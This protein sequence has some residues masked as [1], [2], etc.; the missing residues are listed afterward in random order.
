MS[1]TKS[2]EPLDF[3]RAA[4]DQP[5]QP[6]LTCQ[7]CKQPLRGSYYSVNGHG[8]CAGCLQQLRDQQRG[9]F[10]KAL[11]LGSVAG[12]I[13]A[14][15]YYG[16]REASG[17][18]LGLVT[19]VVGIAVGL[20]V[21]RGAG[22]SQSRLY[23]VLA[24]A[25]TYVAM[26]STHIPSILE[27]FEA[28]ANLVSV[29][30]AGVFSLAIPFFMVAQAEVLSLLIF[31]FGLWEAFRLSA[32]RPFVIEGPFEAERAPAAQ[33]ASEPAAANLPVE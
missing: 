29:I 11:A 19:I 27:G 21:R 3:E 33:A 15:I 17:Y 7:L 26:C 5:A 12:A 2:E 13:G 16:I 20:A 24:V 30:V 28:D 14:A 32:P 22:G 9:S 18:D 6:A 31:G 10:A 25:L 4:F 8:T 1:E 23:R